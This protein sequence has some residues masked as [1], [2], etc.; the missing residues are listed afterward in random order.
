MEKRDYFKPGVTVV[1]IDSEDVLVNKT[2]MLDH[3]QNQIVIDKPTIGT[4]NAGG[5][6]SKITINDVW[7]K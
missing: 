6:A 5:A 1:E 7:D 4:G 2:S 3:D